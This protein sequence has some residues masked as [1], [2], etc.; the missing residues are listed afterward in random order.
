[1]N[2]DTQKYLQQDNSQMQSD[3]TREIKEQLLNEGVLKTPTVNAGIGWDRGQ[4]GPGRYTATAWGQGVTEDGAKKI[5]D[6]RDVGK[7]NQRLGRLEAQG[8]T[9]G[10]S[11]LN[12]ALAGE[13]YGNI[14][15]NTKSDFDKTKG[16]AYAEYTATGDSSNRIDRARAGVL[17]ELR[18]EE[19]RIIGL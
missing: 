8:V 9:A 3:L 12:R 13:L 19:R 10:E 1:M 14:Y 16:N 15:K 6:I 11:L 4:S 5:E 2:Y 17:P 18:E 7:T